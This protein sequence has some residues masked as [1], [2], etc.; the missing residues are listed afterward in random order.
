[1]GFKLKKV[2]K[3]V[4]KFTDPKLHLKN[5][6]RA[7]SGTT[8]KKVIRTIQKYEG[9][10][11]SYAAPIVG[12]LFGGVVGAAAGTAVGTIAR[13]H[14]EGQGARA[15]GKHGSA[16]KKAQRR[17]RKAGLMIGGIVTGGAVIGAAAGVGGL[18][19]GALFSGGASAAGAGGGAAAAAATSGAAAAGG[20]GAGVL[21]GIGAALSTV[22]TLAGKFLGG[23]KVVGA[24][25][26][27]GAADLG[28]GPGPDGGGG[29][30]GDFLD[31]T[32]IDPQTP[33]GKTNFMLFAAA[34]VAVLFLMR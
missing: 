25:G 1:V 29:G 13:Q 3:K 22:G 20:S 10:V 14:G 17:G 15:K 24:S 26:P 5:V 27:E 30:L 16:V 28:S 23:G 34:V 19:T 33:E 21:G 12:G 31:G 32:A 11:V 18:T 8:G 4:K 2:L 9:R 7:V 6:K